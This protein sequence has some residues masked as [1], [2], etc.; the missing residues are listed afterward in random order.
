MSL[1]LQEF[2][3]DGRFCYLLEVPAERSSEECAKPLVD[4][5]FNRLVQSTPGGITLACIAQGNPR[6][7]EMYLQLRK[8]LE[9]G[10]IAFREWQKGQQVRS[11]KIQSE[12]LIGGLDVPLAMLNTET[13]IL[14]CSTQIPFRYGGCDVLRQL[15]TLFLPK[16]SLLSFDTRVQT[17]CAGLLD[18]AWI[19]LSLTVGRTSYVVLCNS[20][21]FAEL[22]AS[23]IGGYDHTELPVLALLAER[24]KSTAGSILPTIASPLSNGIPAR[25]VYRL[26]GFFV[27]VG[28]ISRYTYVTSYKLSAARR[29]LH[30]IPGYIK[31]QLGWQQ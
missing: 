25:R 30:R 10:E 7:E 20:P 11:V 22:I 1:S 21:L 31:K 13:L 23:R 17:E 6:V 24:Y 16:G 15:S 5:L 18:W 3:I 14:F 12:S 26:T 8:K 29:N 19:C 4:G 27:L 28:I 2:E 9:A